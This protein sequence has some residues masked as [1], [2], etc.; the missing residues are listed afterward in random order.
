MS[1]FKMHHVED[2]KVDIL[3]HGRRKNS[4]HILTL[5]KV[6]AEDVYTRLHSNEQMKSFEFI[7]P[8]NLGR[9]EGVEEIDAMAPDTVRSRI[10]IIDVRTSTLTW[11]QQAYNK[12]VGYNRRDLNTSVFNV[13]IGDGPVNLFQNGNSMD[14]FVSHLASLRVD[15]TPAAFFFDP[16]IHYEPDEIP[17]M[18]A[19]QQ[20]HISDKVPKRLLPYFTGHSEPTVSKIRKF[21]RAEGKSEKDKQKR[22]KVLRSVFEQRVKKQFPNHIQKLEQL[23]SKEGIQISTENMHVYPMYFEDWIYELFVKAS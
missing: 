1:D 8:K 7:L 15:Y 6:L 23:M 14:M 21:F 10:I 17:R 3:S 19:E 22:L 9:K 16:F 18:G 12:V 5:D 2:P 13:L 11:L 20:F 4:A